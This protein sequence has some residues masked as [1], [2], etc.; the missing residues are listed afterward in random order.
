MIKFAGKHLKDTFSKI[1]L[2]S[3][4]EEALKLPDLPRLTLEEFLGIIYHT[5]FYKVLS[6][7]EQTKLA[8]LFTQK[9]SCRYSNFLDTNRVNSWI[10]EIH[11]I[12]G[13]PV[14]EYQGFLDS[15]GD[16]IRKLDLSLTTA[17]RES[18]AIMFL[19]CD[20]TPNYQETS[21]PAAVGDEVDWRCDMPHLHS[22]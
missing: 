18:G 22:Y 12:L 11:H 3:P 7:D 19:T 10:G 15:I 8:S 17:Q 21:R 14:L 2:R 6:A 16:D 13:L 4:A 9:I 1:V 20:N 5:D